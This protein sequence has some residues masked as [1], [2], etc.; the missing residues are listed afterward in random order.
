MPSG[1]DFY[2]SAL[3]RLND[4]RKT[5]SR[6]RSVL[7]YYEVVLRAQSEVKSS[8][9]CDTDG[10]D[11]ETCQNRV[12]QG[13]PA[14]EPGDITADWPLFDGLLER[15]GELS[16]R[17][18]EAAGSAGSPPAI[19]GRPVEWH[20][21]L[22][23]GLLQKKDLLAETA[24]EAGVSVEMLAFLACQA[25]T[26]FLESYAESLKGHIDDTAWVRGNCPICGG[27]PLMGRF[28]KETGKRLLQ[29]HLCRTDWAFKRMECP[30][31]GNS[32]QEKMRFFSEEG[33][34]VHRVEVCDV[35]KAYLKVVD[36]RETERAVVLF[37]ENLATIHLDLV[38]KREGFQRDTNRLFGL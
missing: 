36:L 25:L 4:L 20:E 11:I 33:D 5:E 35:C 17:Y 15:I 21:R 38:A 26:P 22:L 37:V 27:E 14:L 1:E 7:D 34:R 31:C 12:S 3:S 29:C 13:T 8:F 6:I 24:D 9:Q 32:D 19:S 18:S 16:R 2:E 30:F 28:E 23:K 10:I